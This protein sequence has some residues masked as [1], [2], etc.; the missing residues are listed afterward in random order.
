MALI[1]QQS[2]AFTNCI[3]NRKNTE[4]YKAL[5]ER[6]PVIG[7]PI[8]RVHARLRLNYVCAWDFANKNNGAIVALATVSLS[9]FTFTLWRSTDKLWSAATQAAE[10][11]ERTLRITERPFVSIKN[12]RYGMIS[13][14]ADRPLIGMRF[15][16]VWENTGNTRAT[17]VKSII[18]ARIFD[19]EEEYRFADLDVI[20]NPAVIGAHST[21]D[22]GHLD[23]TIQR[24]I[25]VMSG[26]KHL[27]MWGRGE[28]DDFIEPDAIQVI[29]FC[30]KVRVFGSIA[31]RNCQANFDV[32][33]NYYRHYQKKQGEPYALP[34]QPIN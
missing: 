16:V 27:F 14:G 1:V 20:A 28:Y 30:Y 34:P 2:E 4:E 10:I 21:L 5:H 22:S 33:G 19:S 25:P 3:K 15:W 8:V 17:N 9:A 12:P 6:S 31:E 32:Y 26:E 18:R 13:P 11:A 29:E 24:M 23:F 7:S